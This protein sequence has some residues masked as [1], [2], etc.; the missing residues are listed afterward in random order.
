MGGVERREP[1]VVCAQGGGGGSLT[2]PVRKEQGLGQLDLLL[3][4]DLQLPCDVMF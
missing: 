1:L 3:E 2:H 4:A